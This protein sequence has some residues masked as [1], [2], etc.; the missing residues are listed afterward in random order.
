MESDHIEY[1]LEDSV[2]RINEIITA[3]DNAYEEKDSIPAR[4]T[5]T[6]T[7]GFYVK[8]SALFVDIR[9][10]SDLTD[11][12]RTRVLAKLYRAYI[13]EVAAVM[14]GSKQC[15][16]INVVG[17]CV[18]GIFDTTIKPH[19]DDVFSTAAQIS[20]IVDIMNYR[21]KKNNMKEIAVGIGM[22][23][24]QALMVKAGYSGSGI[25]EV[26]WMG[27]VVNEASKLSSYGNKESYDPEMMVSKDFY[28]YL[29]DQ[30]KTL[31]KWNNLRSCYSGDIVSTYMN[32][33]YKQNCSP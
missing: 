1:N 23:Y 11:F 24:G 22:A 8:C 19:I 33:W 7:N 12:H 3:S 20:S 17:D 4:N 25:S 21:F 9:E 16:E 10:S 26:I 15:A 14:N 31:L 28:N 32:N 13:S 18:S 29:N 30:N 2:K 6:Y 5:L 27:E